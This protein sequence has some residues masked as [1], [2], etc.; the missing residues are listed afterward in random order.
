MVPATEGMI[1][2]RSPCAKFYHLKIGVQFPSPSL[3]LLLQF[4]SHFLRDSLQ[5]LTSL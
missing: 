4:W 1:A 3:Y 2:F 5:I